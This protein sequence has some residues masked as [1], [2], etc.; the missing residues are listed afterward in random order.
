MTTAYNTDNTGSILTDQ[1]TYL[2]ATPLDFG[3]GHINPNRAMDPGLIYDLDF[4]Q[5]VDFICSLGFNETDMKALLRGQQWNCSRETADI[6]YPSYVFIFSNGSTPRRHVFN[7]V[8]TNVGD[9]QSVYHSKVTFPSGMNITVQPSTLS[10]THKYQKNNFSLTVEVH[11]EVPPVVYG[12]LTWFDEH[13]HTVSSPI[14]A[15]NSLYA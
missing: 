13:Q 8:L 9:A 4:Q 2:P 11:G 3:A 10:F 7:R 5:Y 15:L 14:V 1:A 6:N 12:Y